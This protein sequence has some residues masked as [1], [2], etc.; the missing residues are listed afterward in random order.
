MIRDEVYVTRGIY[1]QQSLGI[2]DSLSIRNIKMKNNPT[3]CNSGNNFLYGGSVM[4]RVTHQQTEY[5]V[6]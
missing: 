4:V 2:L 3:M 6:I 1:Y 5:I